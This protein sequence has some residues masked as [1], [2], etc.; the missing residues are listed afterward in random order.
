VIF[1]YTDRK[2]PDVWGLLFIDCWDWPEHQEF[3]DCVV[4]NVKKINYTSTICSNAENNKL[5]PLLEEKI[6]N[7]DTIYLNSPIEFEQQTH[8]VNNWIVIGAAWAICIHHGPMGLLKTKSILDHQFYV[9]PEWS[10]FTVMNEY[11][12][13]KELHED[14][15]T[16]GKITNKCY[17]FIGGRNEAR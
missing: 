17:Q 15:C 4:E 3:H 1:N 7:S 12:T 5:S 2:L 8:V 11:I 13:E 16:W 14:W 6:F 10:I 9:F